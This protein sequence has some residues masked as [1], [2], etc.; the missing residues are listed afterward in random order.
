ME[1]T[2]LNWFF[3]GFGATLGWLWKVLWDAIGGLKKDIREIERVLPEI[4]VR[5][6][7]FKEAISELKSEIRESRQDV[8]L[9]FSRVDDALGTI[10]AELRK[11]EDR[12]V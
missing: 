2:I 3:V 12:H 1:Q 8:K 6:D 5:K 4:Y 9:G 11:K 10:F 7:D